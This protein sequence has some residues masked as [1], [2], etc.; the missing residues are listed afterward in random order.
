M[1]LQVYVLPDYQEITLCSECAVKVRNDND[2]YLIPIGEPAPN[3][4]QQC[5]GECRKKRQQFRAELSEQA[6]QV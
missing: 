1:K 4:P 6:A 3:E 2:G 5:Q